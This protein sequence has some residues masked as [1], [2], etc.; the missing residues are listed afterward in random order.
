MHS[1]KVM[2]KGYLNF[3]FNKETGRNATLIHPFSVMFLTDFSTAETLLLI[4]MMQKGS[5]YYLNLEG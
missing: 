5:V 2:S 3:F 4:V 1:I